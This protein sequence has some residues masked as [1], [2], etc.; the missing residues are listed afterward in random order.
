MATRRDG[1]LASDAVNT[2]LGLL[3]A[4]LDALPEPILLYNDARVVFANAAAHAALG[5]HKPGELI[6]QALETFLLPDLREVSEERRGWVLRDGVPVHNLQMKIVRNDG[7]VM[8]VA[9]DI[10]PICCDGVTVGMVTLAR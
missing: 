9:V 10:R 1:D 5:A 3:R 2:D 4:A 6:G 7:E 8:L